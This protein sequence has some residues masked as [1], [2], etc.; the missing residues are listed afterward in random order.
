MPL[1]YS[2]GFKEIVAQI[3]DYEAVGVDTLF[4]PEAYS[5][6][7]VSLL[8]YLAAATDRIGIAS[9]IFN[10]YSRTPTL[11]AMTA[12]GLDYVSDGRFMLGIGASGPQVV[13]GFHGQPYRAPLGRAREV[14]DI[15][16]MVW[17]RDVVEFR[18][19]HFHL[20]LDRDHGGTGLGK[21]LKI[22]NKP[23][24][25]RIPIMLAAMG[26][27][28]V[29]LAAEH[30]EAWQPMFYLP[31]AAE[32]VFG[33]SLRDGLSRRDAALGPLDIVATSYLAIVDNDDE[34]QAARQQVRE[35]IA[36]YVG[37][38]GAK[39]KNFYAS[40]VSRFGYA[41]EASR[42]QDLYL[43]GRRDEAAAAVP[44]EL[45]RGLGLI[46]TAED[47]AERVTAFARAGVTTMNLRPLAPDHKSRLRDFTIVRQ[48]C[49]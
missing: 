30:F 2:G 35:H 32:S 25:G 22:I 3:R 15:C 6:D 34:A 42:I 28:A 49:P 26:D 47:I 4:V 10:V 13:E 16:R 18:G 23:V 14:A 21:P 5:F 7:S 40:L 33:A 37:G 41:E 45:V 27:K 43:A 17:R 12:A 11:I 8:G 44:D 9:S 1:P 24:R 38:M 48:M 36:L 20:P 46:G 19:E 31:E 39:G 29:A